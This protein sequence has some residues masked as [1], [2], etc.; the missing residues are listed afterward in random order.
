[1]GKTTIFDNAKTF[2]CRF[3]RKILSTSDTAP[4]SSLNRP[5]EGMS[6][7]T[8]DIKTLKEM[9]IAIVTIVTKDQ[10]ICQQNQGGFIYCGHLP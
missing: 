7:Y 1:M 6:W 2:F 3:N 8:A 4:E 9:D 5:Q 10:A